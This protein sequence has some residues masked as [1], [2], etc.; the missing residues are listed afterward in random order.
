MQGHKFKLGEDVFLSP[1]PYLRGAPG[2]V[3]TVVRQLPEEAGEFSYRIKSVSE[4]H[5]RAVKESQIEKA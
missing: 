1:S 2:G 3:Y 5:E 4:G